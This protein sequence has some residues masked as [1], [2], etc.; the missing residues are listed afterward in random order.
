MGKHTEGPWVCHSGMV[1]KDGPNVFPK[2]EEDGIPIARMD[3]ETEGTT[4]TE[5]DANARLIALVPELLSA[6]ENLVSGYDSEDYT[7]GVMIDR[8]VRLQKARNLVAK[9]KGENENG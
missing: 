1:W 7:G 6:L 2:G 4:P 5:R 3:R 9:A 8:A